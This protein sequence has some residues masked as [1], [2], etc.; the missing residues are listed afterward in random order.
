MTTIKTV[1]EILDSVVIGFYCTNGDWDLDVSDFL[2]SCCNSISKDIAI[3]YDGLIALKTIAK[4]YENDKTGLA[5]YL[6]DKTNNEVSKIFKALT[7]QY[8]PK[9]NYYRNIYE[10]NSGENSN[11]YSGTDTLTNSGTDT[12]TLTDDL[13]VDESVTKNETVNSNNTYDSATVEGFRPTNKS[14]NEYQSHEDYNENVTTEKE[15]GKVETQEYGKV[16]TTNFGRSKNTEIE[17]NNGIHPFPD[18]IK[19]EF[20]LR[21]KHEL[22]RSIVNIIVEQVS[23]G[24]W[25]DE[26]DEDED[27]YI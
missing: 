23:A 24:V 15:Y 17:G 1:P 18:L 4:V 13:D 7:V 25:L 14:E 10:V 16:L 20:D 19:K 9:Y 11:V 5:Q 27:L 22:F 21:T 26:E 6:F 12:T 3:Q 2:I 8:N